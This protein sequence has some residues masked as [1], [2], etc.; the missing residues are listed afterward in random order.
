MSP[1]TT[2]S[3]PAVETQAGPEETGPEETGPEETGPEETGEEVVRVTIDRREKSLQQLSAS[4]QAFSETDLERRNVVSLRELTAVTP[5]VEVGTQEGN[6]ELYIRGIGNN[7]NTEIGDPSAAVH[8]DG[9][10]I[11]RPR[12]LGSAYFDLE[13][14]ELLRGPQGT[15]RGRNASAGTMNLVTAA[16]KLG[17][18]AARGTFQYGNYMQRLTKA[19]VNIPIGDKLALR[20]A[21]FTENHDPFYKNQGGNPN[22]RASEDANTFAYRVSLKWQP[23]RKISVIL[24]HDNTFER[25]TGALGTN[26]TQALQRGIRPEEIPDVRALAYRGHQGQM[27]LD[28]MG[29]SADVNFDFGPVS[30]QVLNSYRSLKYKQ[31]T[32]DSAGA[33]YPGKE[34]PDLDNYSSTYWETTSKSVVNELRLYSPDT[35]M[36]RWTLGGFHFYESQGVFLGQVY[37]KVWGYAGGEYN[38]K[39]IKDGAVAGYADGTLDITKVWRALAGFRLT[40]DYKHRNGVGYG[41]PVGCK[42]APDAT[43]TQAEIDAC[44]ASNRMFR[45]GTEGYTPAGLGRTDYTNS[46]ALSDYTNGVSQFGAR[47][48][49]LAMY[50]RPGSSVPTMTE[51]HGKTSVLVPDFRV[52][53]EHD[54]GPQNMVYAT[55]STGY[56]SGGFND[57]VGNNAYSLSYK[58]EKVYAT[59]LGSKNQFVEKRITLNVAGFWYAYNDYQTNNVVQVSESVSQTDDTVRALNSS[60]RTNVGNARVL[61]LEIESSAIIVKGFR[62][63]L[64]ASLLDARFLG[65]TV[66]DTRAGW[67]AATQGQVNL[68]GNFLPRAPRL[69]LAYG[70]SQTI[71]TSIG[72]WSW[73]AWGQ[74]KSK[75]YMTQFNG[76]GYRPDGTPDPVFSDAVPWTHRFD[77][78]V[79]YTRPK[80]D[81]TIDAFVTNIT[82]MTYMT[83]LIN[84]PS[85]NLRFYNPPRQMGL[86]LTMEI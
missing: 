21:T 13:R 9:V 54:L 47:D 64:S 78:S 24:R 85:T 20:V 62:A 59:E 82:N 65:A 34:A 44:N 61:G 75:M 48:D 58:P 18:W 83:S 28:H 26:V 70:L 16:P 56:R 36:F 79:G 35:S 7:N 12:G 30:L 53:I 40:Y 14:V 57:V 17:E 29:V 46:N 3:P 11:P 32:G 33:I 74:T 84:V 19:M 76:N 69:A 5:F 15:L 72:Y 25:G 68:K 86:R 60:L 8:I 1:D 45:N 51:Q 71:P 4:A 52:G 23:V 66:A 81:I 50:Q 10:Y 41:L 77:A 80:S 6:F 2:L 67:D 49:L 63:S 42:S 31:T 43:T 38:Y 27:A 39:D 73:G 55:F 22:L 37:D